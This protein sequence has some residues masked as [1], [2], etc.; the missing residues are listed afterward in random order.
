MLAVK[1]DRVY[2]NDMISK[3]ADGRGLKKTDVQLDLLT[4]HFLMCPNW[5]RKLKVVIAQTLGMTY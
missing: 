2:A 4:H 5:D 3:E 1:A